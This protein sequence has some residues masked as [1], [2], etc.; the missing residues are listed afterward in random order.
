VINASPPCRELG[1]LATASRHHPYTRTGVGGCFCF[2]KGSIV[3]LVVIIAVIVVVVAV[4]VAIA[5]SFDSLGR[6]FLEAVGSDSSKSWY[7]I[8][9]VPSGFCR[10][11]AAGNQSSE[12]L[13]PYWTYTCCPI[14]NCSDMIR[15]YMATCSRAN[16]L[17]TLDSPK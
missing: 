8:V 13:V 2:I 6:C 17:R 11:I 1:N 9:Y 14:M 5:I 12:R 3:D 15:W 4:I 7:R 16:N 10:W